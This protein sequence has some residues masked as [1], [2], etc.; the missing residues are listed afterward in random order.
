M[1]EMATAAGGENFLLSYAWKGQATS[2]FENLMRLYQAGVE[3]AYRHIGA[4]NSVNGENVLA[5]FAAPNNRPKIE[6]L[7]EG[8]WVV[9]MPDELSRAWHSSGLPHTCDALQEFMRRPEVIAAF[10]EYCEAFKAFLKQYF[11]EQR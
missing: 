5:S 9:E 1:T 2:T 4:F 6:R 7:S 3:G 8:S 11:K 10:P